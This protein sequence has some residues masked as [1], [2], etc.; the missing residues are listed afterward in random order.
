MQYILIHQKILQL[1]ESAYNDANDILN[2]FRNEL[3]NKLPDI[4]QVRDVDLEYTAKKK[5]EGMKTNEIKE[6]AIIRFILSTI[7]EN[8]QI[9]DDNR[10]NDGLKFIYD[11]TIEHIID[12]EN[13]FDNVNSLG[14]LILLEG[15][16]HTNDK[17]K[18]KMYDK[19][20]ITMT[21][22]FHT[23]YPDFEYNKIKGRKNNLIKKFYD[24]VK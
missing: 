10:G 21:K 1:Q 7:A 18:I 9:E 5:S 19:S 17:D 23:N 20:K 4:K 14:N 11:S 24:I 15:N 16:I 22:N 13:K 2:E 12:K 8:M 3:K 6:H